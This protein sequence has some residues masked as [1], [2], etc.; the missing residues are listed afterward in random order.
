MFDNDEGKN[1]GQ[2]SAEKLL[3]ELR[4]AGFNAVNKILSERKNFDVNDFLQ[5]DETALKNRLFEI[6]NSAKNIFVE[7]NEEISLKDWQKTNGKISAKKFDE[8]IQAV[9][10]LKSAEI[11]AANISKFQSSCALCE[12]YG[13]AEKSFEFKTKLKDFLKDNEIGVTITDF[14]SK[15]VKLLT[16]EKKF[17]REYLKK[18]EREESEK[19]WKLREN[20]IK[21]RTAATLLT[22]FSLPLHIPANY[23]ISNRGIIQI[24]P[25]GQKQTLIS[26]TPILPKKI[27][28]DKTTQEI[29]YEISIKLNKKWVNVKI[30]GETLQ[31]AKGIT[32]LCNYGAKFSSATANLM[33]AFMTKIIGENEN[34][35][36]IVES[37]PQ[38][39]W[40]DQNFNNFAY[41]LTNE[42]NYIVDRAGTNYDEIFDTRGNFVAWKEKFVEVVKNG[43]NIA[44][45][46]VGACLA[47]PLVKPLG[48]MN[49]HVHLEGKSGIG[50]S[51]LPKFGA[52]IFGNPDTGKL[53]KTFAATAKNR[54]ESA[55]ALSDFPIILEELESLKKSEQDQIAQTIYDY[56]LGVANQAQIR[57]GT[58]RP[59]VNFS[60][61]R[62]STGERAL[63][64]VNDKRGAFKRI[65]NIR[66]EKLFS[67]T[68]AANLHIFT[69]NNFGLFGRQWINFIIGNKKA[70]R[71]E[72]Y[73]LLKVFQT[74]E[75]FNGEP[76]HLKNLLA[77]FVAYENFVKCAD[78]PVEVNIVADFEE[79]LKFLLTVY[80]YI[81]STVM[82]LFQR[83]K[84]L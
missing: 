38:T 64:D 68:F 28:R 82:F 75:I 83:R 76:T 79:S 45:I 21:G 26:E 44:K 23:D 71:E 77:C 57:K 13:L 3:K 9:N 51:P 34:I 30:D 16:D 50:K 66:A 10:F 52:S 55:V 43:G 80:I 84:F 5:E 22:D 12:F 4:D 59:I 2:E 65:L 73:D 33:A 35:L 41:P 25:E 78:I 72:F 40:I 8:V 36:P 37:Y 17:H 24:S 53:S 1:A 18:L 70:I 81:I 54:I 42:N 11:N 61:V 6:Y 15:L 46:I 47:A 20:E 67:D 32:S 7:T 49:F 27:L 63:L 60:G 39:G 69:E 14:K 48:L 56:S 74:A 62:I 29:K 19:L 31:T 58:S